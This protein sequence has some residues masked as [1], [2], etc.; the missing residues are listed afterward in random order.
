MTPR[1][2]EIAKWTLFLV[3]I[4]GAAALGVAAWNPLARSNSA[5]SRGANIAAGSPFAEL[6]RLPTSPRP[7]FKPGKPVLLAHASHQS[8][9][10]PVVRAVV[11][12]RRPTSDAP[13]VANLST[14]TPE[15]TTNLVV[16]TAETEARGTLWAHVQLPILPN[17]RFGWVPRSALGGYQFVSTRLV[18]DR[19]HLLATLFRGG[20]A[21]F[22]ASVGVG[23]ANWPTPAGN[24]YIRERL[25]TFH[26]PFYGPVAFGTS[27]RSAVLTDWPGGGFI[28]IHGTDRPDLLPGRVSHGCIRL[29][30]PDILR[31]SRLMPVGTPVTIQ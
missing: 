24:F 12:R 14:K 13:P 18:I 25:T 22:R 31:L 9:W 17:G 19:E 1:R 28:G 23:Q 8:R 30:N 3:L 15:G 2:R 26:S 11:A 27:G 6:S 10:A 4:A 7:A 16:V 21:V 29:R 5:E 20:R